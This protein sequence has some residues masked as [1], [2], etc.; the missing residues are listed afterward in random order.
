MTDIV[1]NLKQISEE[2]GLSKADVAK[3]MGV[4]RS[5]ITRWFN[6]TANPNVYY[7]QKMIDVLGCKIQITN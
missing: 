6:G 5:S 1:K 3:R 4:P 7:V 2:K